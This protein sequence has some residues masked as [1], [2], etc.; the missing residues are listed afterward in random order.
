MDANIDNSIDSCIHKDICSDITKDYLLKRLYSNFKQKKYLN[1]YICIRYIET[2]KSITNKYL[3][4]SPLNRYLCIHTPKHIEK[5]FD[6][7]YKSIII[8]NFIK[9]TKHQNKEKIILNEINLYGESTKNCKHDCIY[10]KCN[11]T[12]NDNK[13]HIFTCSELNKIIT[14]ALL[15]N[16]ENDNIISSRFP[17]NS[18]TNKKFTKNELEYIMYKF[19]KYNFHYHKIILMFHSCN[20]SIKQLSFDYSYYLHTISAQ[21]YIKNLDKTEFLTL[22]KS[23]WISMSSSRNSRRNKR[24]D[25]ILCKHCVLSIPTLQLELNNILSKYYLEF[26]NTIPFSNDDF[27]ALNNLKLTFLKFLIV[28]YPHVYKNTDYYHL[29]YNKYNKLRFKKK[30]FTFTPMIDFPIHGF[31]DDC[32]IIYNC[33]GLKCIIRNQVLVSI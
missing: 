28:T 16:F 27:I 10:L 7:F 20:F 12:K 26:H 30:T 23:F 29:H 32:K 2:R 19:K 17:K 21:T 9:K 18:W 33:N 5:V 1:L 6:I 13:Y 4:N 8:Y 3:N 15:F 11:K 31:T 22:F 24:L 14:N 25:N